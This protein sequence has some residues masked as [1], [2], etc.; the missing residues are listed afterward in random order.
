MRFKETNLLYV[1]KTINTRQI[2]FVTSV[3]AAT[4]LACRDVCIH[5]NV[6]PAGL[7]LA[8]IVVSNWPSKEREMMDDLVGT[9]E[10]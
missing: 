8:H 5:L 10:M 4:H 7:N 2:F 3:L 9:W 1:Y 6:T